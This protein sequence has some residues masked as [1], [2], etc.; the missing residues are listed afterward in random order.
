MPRVQPVYRCQA[1]GSQTH[2]FFGRCP[3]C[4]AWNTLLEEAPPA[5]SLTSQRDQ[6]S[7]T[8]P[9]S[10]PMATVEPMA[11]VRIS[12]GSGELDRVLGAL[13]EVLRA[14]LG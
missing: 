10:Q 1:C 9:R 4:G 7:S 8:A 2:Q 11:E 12:T 13:E 14:P 5:R 3:S 6:P